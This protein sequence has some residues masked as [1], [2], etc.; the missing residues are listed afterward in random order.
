[1]LDTDCVVG[2]SLTTTLTTRNRMEESAAR[3]SG[4][5]STANFGALHDVGRL[6]LRI[7]MFSRF[8]RDFRADDAWESCAVPTGNAL[9]Q[10]VSK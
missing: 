3:C 2:R 6:T 8:C 9:R 5:R 4:E 7:V 10:D 1:M